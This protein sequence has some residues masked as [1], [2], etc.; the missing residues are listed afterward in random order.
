MAN[1]P[2]PNTFVQVED[3]S[4]NTINIYVGESGSNRVYQI[5]DN[6]TTESLSLITNLTV[7]GF[8]SGFLALSPDTNWLVTSNSGNNTASYIR[9]TSFYIFNKYSTGSG[10][11]VLVITDP[12]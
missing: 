3:S 10:P 2:L 7:G 5:Q 6:R 8:N 11:E 12:M 4:S 1:P 9:L